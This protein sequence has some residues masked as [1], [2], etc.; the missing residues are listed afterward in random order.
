MNNRLESVLKNLVQQHTAQLVMPSQNFNDRVEQVAHRLAREGI[1][2]L[3]GDLQRVHREHRNDHAQAWVNAYA[4]LYY[5]FS[6]GLYGTATEPSAYFVDQQYPMIIVFKADMLPLVRIMAG[7]FM[8]YIALRQSDGRATRAELRGVMEMA[9]DELEGNDLPTDQYNAL[10]AR[11]IEI[12]DTLLKSPIRQVAL[13]EFDQPF[14]IQT[15]VFETPVKDAPRPD[16][17]PELPSQRPD[18]Q[19]QSKRPLPPNVL[20]MPAPKKSAFAPPVPKPRLL[21]RIQGD[22]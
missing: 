14:L 6:Q 8:P 3:V 12:L 21:D 18:K 7:L 22:S 19:T 15:G 13:T 17:L 5:L 16:S 20:Q 9:L 4:E 2:I 11:G 1:L 10:R